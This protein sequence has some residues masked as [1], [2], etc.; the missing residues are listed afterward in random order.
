MKDL[1]DD[2]SVVMNIRIIIMLVDSNF[3]CQTMEISRNISHLEYREIIFHILL[4]N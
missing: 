2:T 1:F 3:V 4:R